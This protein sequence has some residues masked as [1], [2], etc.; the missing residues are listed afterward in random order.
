MENTIPETN[1]SPLKIDPLKRKFLLET[2][3][4]RCYV[5]F[6]EGR[7]GNPGICNEIFE[8]TNGSFRVLLMKSQSFLNYFLCGRLVL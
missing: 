2:I 7:F 3:I 6:R 4:F 5:S 8:D 1:S